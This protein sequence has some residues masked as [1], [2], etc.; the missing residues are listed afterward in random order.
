MSS[1]TLSKEEIPIWLN[2]NFLCD[3]LQISADRFELKSVQYACKKGENFASKIFRIVCNDGK[4]QRSIIL[5]SRPFNDKSFSE[6]FLKQFNI[7]PKEIE[8]YKLVQTFEEILCVA[9]IR[10][11]FSARSNRLNSCDDVN[12]I[13]N[14]FQM[15][16]N[17]H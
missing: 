12:N 6:D 15:S 17:H 4:R 3:L 13:K 8:A 1:L 5:K 9:G 14:I 2:A 10:T 7:F 11:S 16:K